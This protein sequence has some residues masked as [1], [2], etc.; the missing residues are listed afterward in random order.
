[1]LMEMGSTKVT[2]YNNAFY[3]VFNNLKLELQNWNDN[4]ICEKK[5]VAR[6]RMSFI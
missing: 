6:L 4:N 5:K 2:V 3:F 1:M